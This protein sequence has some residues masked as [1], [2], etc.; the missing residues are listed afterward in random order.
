MI[1]YKESD[2]WRRIS[3]RDTPFLFVLDWSCGW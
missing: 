3:F 1:N 2:S